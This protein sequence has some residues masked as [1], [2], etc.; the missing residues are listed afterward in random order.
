MTDPVASVMEQLHRPS[1][2]FLA[3]R[4]HS[5][6]TMFL[7]AVE[8]F[9]SRPAYIYRKADDAWTTMSWV[10]TK[11]RVFEVAAGLLALGVGYEDRVAIA[12]S[13]RI[14]WI[15]ID[16]GIMCAAGATTTVYPNTK[17]EDVWHIV[18]DSG[19]KV[20]FA[21]NAAQLDKVRLHR[22]TLDSVTRVVVLDPE[23]VED[24]DVEGTKAMSWDAFRRLGADWLA[25]H[26]QSVHES[27]A[28][29]HEDTLSTLIY[30]SG[31][32][33]RPKGVRL[34]HRS[35]TT[36][37]YRVGQEMGILEHDDIHFLML[38]LS[39]VFGKCL[40]TLS[41]TSGLVHAVE[42]DMTRIVEG[43]GQVRPTIMASAPRV[44]EKVRTAVILK[45][46]RGVTARIARW[47][48]S[49]GQSAL[50]YTTTGLRLPRSLAIRYRI[51]DKLVFSKLKA[52]MGGR[53]RWF[54]S[55]SAQLNPQVQ[56]WFFA[57]GIPLIEGYGMTETAAITCLDDPKRPGLGTVGRP[58]PGNEVRIA[59][60]GEILV[61]S[62]ALLVGYH[63]LPDE[64]AKAFVEDGWFCTG[65][66][67]ELDDQGRLR[68]TDRKKD[69]IKTSGG[70]YVAPQKVEGA[71]V[72][73]IPYVSQAFV[74]GDG[75]KY[76]SVLL[77]LD[78]PSIMK[79]AASHGHEGLS[80]AEVTQNEDVRGMIGHYM[81]KA[82]ARLERWETVK[83]FEIL[84]RELS[85]DDG[86]V[87]PTMKVRRSA[88][89][90]TFADKLAKLYDD[91][92]IG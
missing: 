6:G 67:G 45:N 50:P 85:V 16:L 74:Q 15:L 5:V 86:E 28:T 22:D 32:T 42:G 39:H 20:V 1:E 14:E 76:I 79:W 61:R 43:L 80:Y 49:V 48:F 12:S 17:D 91:E 38:P 7:A 36:L 73:N 34:A 65:D 58:V 25:A 70:K 21:E 33:G 26:P 81:E 92:E 13:T 88:V 62:P 4:E 83:R 57:A 23:G 40:I 68:I 72:N 37:G 82:N 84:D 44:F 63:N 55:G 31:T 75:R 66:I 11:E 64:A 18:S 46:H 3:R 19:S 87:T 78:E 27:I 77:T 54:V 60:D 35:W 51:A 9:G 10:E 69:L 90:A 29:T 24:I 56:K 59:D 47:A 41:F 2:A 52:T 89:A 30:T 8:E 53:V 71:I